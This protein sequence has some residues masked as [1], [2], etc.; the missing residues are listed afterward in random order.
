MAYFPEIKPSS[1]KLNSFQLSSSYSDSAALFKKMTEAQFNRFVQERPAREVIVYIKGSLNC[2]DAEKVLLDLAVYLA[3]NDRKKESIEVSKEIRN[4]ELKFLCFKKMASEEVDE[5]NF[6]ALSLGSPL[7]QRKDK[8]VGFAS[9]VI[10]SCYYEKG[11]EESQKL[12]ALANE[13]TKV[14][15]WKILFNELIT[16]GKKDEAYQFAEKEGEEALYRLGL[17]LINSKMMKDI[18]IV[19]SKMAGKKFEAKLKKLVITTYSELASKALLNH[20]YSTAIENLDHIDDEAFFN[21]HLK[22]IFEEFFKNCPQ[23]AFEFAYALKK[24]EVALSILKGIL[25]L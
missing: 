25:S 15:A 21:S 20:D 18:G 1:F 16:T 12:L 23:D 19:L 3:K 14:E 7:I 22:T 10:L 4:S 17:Y 13:E 24:K 5:L 11:L 8:Q 6:S 9:D 2:A